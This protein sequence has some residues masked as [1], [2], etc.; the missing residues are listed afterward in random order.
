MALLQKM[1]EETAQLHRRFL[2]GQETAGT[3][4][5]VAPGTPATPDPGG[6]VTAV[7]RL[8]VLGPLPRHPPLFPLAASVTAE[9]AFVPAPAGD[10]DDRVAAHTGRGGEREDRLS[11]RDA[12]PRHGA[13]RRPRHRLHQAGG[14]P[15]RP[16]G[17]TPRRTASSARNTSARCSTLG[18]IAALPRRGRSRVPDGAGHCYGQRAAAAPLGDV[19]RQPSSRW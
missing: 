18:E 12:R 10:A 8:A 3:D 9:P 6:S 4:L 13:R 1:Q 19:S 14:D 5:P 7:P 17:A 11:G 16:P 15:L 2:E